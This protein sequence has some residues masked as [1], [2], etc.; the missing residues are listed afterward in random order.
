VLAWVCLLGQVVSLAERGFSRSGELSVLL[1][2]LLSALVVG[3]VS[4]GVLRGRT[5]RLVLVWILFV[6]GLVLGFFGVLEELSRVPAL[7]VLQLAVLVAQVVVLAVFCQS[8]YVRRQ[9]ARPSPAR[10]PSI[11]A[12]VLVAVVVG[13]LGGLTAAPDGG[14]RP[15]QVR[16]GL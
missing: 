4:A 5:G 14:S 8:D 6:A 9:R 10:E 2:M 15:P 12:L 1:S 11:A 13:L 7:A 3:W 16:I